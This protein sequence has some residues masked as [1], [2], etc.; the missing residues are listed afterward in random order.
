M[1]VKPKPITTRLRVAAPL[2]QA[3]MQTRLQL[4]PASM[5]AKRDLRDVQ[6]MH[7]RLCE[8]VG[9]SRQEARLLWRADGHILTVQAAR[10]LDLS[11]LPPGY[12]L[13][14]ESHPVR[15]DWS[16]GDLVRWEIV[17]NPLKTTP[18]TG[19]R[20]GLTDPEECADW[21]I[22][23]LRKAGIEPARI[24]GWRLPPGKGRHPRGEITVARWLFTGA[25][26]VAD[27]AALGRA[28]S[29]GIGKARAYG[30]GLLSVGEMPPAHHEE[31]P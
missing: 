31:E 3:I 22:E 21:M 11:L 10:P 9:A 24:D 5:D 6:R 16:E 27:P 30:V 4:N 8:A 7:R 26:R 2:E 25:G 28:I 19:R 15:L 20:V 1:Q 12:A 29:E 13:G 14:A 23:R 18:R 17:A